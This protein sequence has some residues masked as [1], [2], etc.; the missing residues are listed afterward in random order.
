MTMLYYFY[1]I[2]FHLNRMTR[3]FLS[4]LIF[5]IVCIPIITFAHEV[6]VLQPDDI[7][8]AVTTASPNPFDVIPSQ[9]QQFIIWGILSIIIVLVVLTISISPLFERMF[10]PILFR[11]KK[12][13]P[14]ICRITVGISLYSSGYHQALFGPELPLSQLFT[15]P[16]EISIVSIMLMFFGVCI[17]FGFLTRF[18]SVLGICL[19]IYASFVHHTYMLMYTDYL[20]ALLF[21]IIYGGHIW[22]IENLLPIKHRFNIL[23]SKI[24]HRFESYSFLIL[25]VFLGVAIFYASFYA[26]FLHS[27]LALSTVHSYQ[28]TDY[29]HFT[30][31]FLVLGAFILEAISGICIAIGFEIR[32]VVLFLAFF[33][34]Q[35]LLFF[36]E[37]LW[38]HIILF[39][40]ALSVFF[41]GY[42]RYTMEK[43]LFQRHRKGEPVL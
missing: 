13:A 8:H 43:A 25:R 5:L 27:N 23:F 1:M 14:F 40:L 35:S 22:S 7:Q 16:L 19:Y 32:F 3:H 6:Y 41:H 17:T 30:P 15:N 12:I 20:G 26:K 37:D 4:V 34:T 9:E 2:K 38:P 33:L 18:F 28:L 29:F 36:G 24:K 21:L 31:L 39:G 10:D 42:D 11:L